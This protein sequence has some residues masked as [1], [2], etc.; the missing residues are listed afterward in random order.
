MTVYLCLPLQDENTEP[1]S[2]EQQRQ[3]Q[4]GQGASG[5]GSVQGGRVTSILAAVKAEGAAAPTSSNR[6]QQQ[7]PHQ[8][9]QPVLGRAAARLLRDALAAGQLPGLPNQQQMQYFQLADVPFR[10]ADLV[11]L[12]TQFLVADRTSRTTAGPSDNCSSSSRQTRKVQK[13]TQAEKHYPQLAPALLALRDTV[14]VLRQR[15]VSHIPASAVTQTPASTRLLLALRSLQDWQGRVHL[16]G[17]QEVPMLLRLLLFGGQ[18]PGSAAAAAA[19]A[20]DGDG[21]VEV[22]DLLSGSEGEE[23]AGEKQQQRLAEGFALT[24]VKQGSGGFS[25]ARIKQEPLES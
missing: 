20:A 22:V 14:A 21:V 25:S 1:A 5:V 15:G 19:A 8:Q 2:L 3:Q 17:Q 16:A 24:A 9:Q 23:E 12:H 13:V 4:L 10:A 6:K 18:Q 11:A 7:E